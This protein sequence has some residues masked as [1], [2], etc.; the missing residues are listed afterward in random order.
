MKEWSDKNWYNS[1][2]S[3]KGLLYR[4]W[5]ESI[6]EWR[7]KEF[8][9]P[10]IKKKSPLPPIEASVDPSPNGACQ[11]KCSHCNAYKYLG[12]TGAIPDKGL[13]DLHKFLIDWGVLAFCEGGGGEPTLRKNL[14]EIFWL[15]K[16][17][18]RQSS[19]ATNAIAFNDKLIEAMANCC[20]WV[21]CSVD[22]SNEETYK[23]GRK[24]DYFKIVIKNILLLVKKVREL[25]TNCDVAYK[26]LIT[27]YNYNEI[28]DAC[29]LAQSLGVNDYH[30]RPMDLS[31]QGMGNQK[32]KNFQYSV[33]KIKE[34]FQ[35]CHQLE[36]EN[37]KVYT[38]T[39]KY[40]ENFKPRKNFTQCYAMPLVI[41]CCPDGNVYA[42]V[43]Q[44]LQEDYKL[45]SY[46]PNPE[47]ILNFW[48][49]KKHYDLAFGDTPKKCNTRCTFTKY[50]EQ[51][52]MLF[53]NDK[54]LM[55]INF[56]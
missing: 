26:F 33:D 55:C 40:D 30:C 52:E 4:K 38:V 21:A 12:K 51:C 15:I 5:Y 46:Y 43:D 19:I 7:D 34:Q 18:N 13:I 48:G 1:F 6:I 53:A 37:F 45:G 27:P 17:A 8:V 23:K 2:N 31:H 44:R 54:D 28:Y 3:A 41:Q 20:R 42:C 22:A 47:N 16:K 29:K 32:I 50:C 25:N 39:H 24:G 35:K 9:S 49:E 36:D 10:F 56:T 14:S 11:L